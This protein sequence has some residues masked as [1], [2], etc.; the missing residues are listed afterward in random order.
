MAKASSR[1]LGQ[2]VYRIRHSPVLVIGHRSLVIASLLIA[3]LVIASF[4]LAPFQIAAA[5]VIDADVCI[6]G[7]TSAGIA[8]AVQSARMGKRAVIAEPG[9]YLGGLTT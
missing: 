3:S 7:A 4:V 2:S 9:K 1:T 8:A 6:F 5:A